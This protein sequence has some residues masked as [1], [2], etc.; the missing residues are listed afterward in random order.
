MGTSA[1]NSEE[2]RG[3]YFPSP[4]IYLARREKTENIFEGDEW[5]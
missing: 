4:Y 1:K 2:Q 3:N 5:D